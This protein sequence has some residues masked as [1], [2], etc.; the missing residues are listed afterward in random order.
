MLYAHCEGCTC[1]LLRLD[2]HRTNDGSQQW[3]QFRFA[4]LNTVGAYQPTP[5]QVTAVYPQLASTNTWVTPPASQWVPQQFANLSHAKVLHCNHVSY[6]NAVLC[7]A[8][9]CCA[10][11]CCAVLCC[12]V[13]CCA[14]LWS[15]VVCCA[16]LCCAVQHYA[17]M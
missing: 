1:S 17:A 5:N 9:L 4:P 16:V 2:S 8:V 14:V 7:C 12:A 6:L 10:V 15:A 13:L 11:L 3:A